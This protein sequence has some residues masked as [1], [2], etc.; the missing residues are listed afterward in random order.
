LKGTD[1][2][3]SNP[4]SIQQALTEAVDWLTAH[5]GRHGK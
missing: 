4:L 1:H 3:L 5:V 2:R